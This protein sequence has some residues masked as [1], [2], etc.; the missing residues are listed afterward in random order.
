MKNRIDDLRNHLFAQLE[1]LG[2]EQLDKD[3][4]DQEIKRARAV[5]DVADALIDTA[6][7]E[8]DRM[9]AVA[10]HG[11]RSGTP[12]LEKAEHGQPALESGQR[13]H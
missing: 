7:A 3:Q 12:L 11:S 1:R 6:K 5:R 13:G 2:D 9:V 4:L 8:T 10:E